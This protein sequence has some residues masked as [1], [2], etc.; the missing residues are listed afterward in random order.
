MGQANT[1]LRT[2]Y[3][4]NGRMNRKINESETNTQNLK[5]QFKAQKGLQRLQKMMAEG[6]IDQVEFERAKKILEASGRRLGWKPSHDIPRRREGFHHT[7][8]R[9]IRESE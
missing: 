7:V 1:L 2:R 8:N 6:H 5:A 9:V 3:L 4:P